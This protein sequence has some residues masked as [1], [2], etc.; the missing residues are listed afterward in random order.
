MACTDFSR[1]LASAYFWKA[2]ETPVPEENRSFTSSCQGLSSGDL[3]RH[4]WFRLRDPQHDAGP[5]SSILPQYQ[6]NAFFYSKPTLFGV[7][8]FILWLV[9]R[10]PK[11]PIVRCLRTVRKSILRKVNK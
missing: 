5:T 2:L 1:R 6:G 10:G 8:A 9:I 11:P 7:S 3:A 4:Q